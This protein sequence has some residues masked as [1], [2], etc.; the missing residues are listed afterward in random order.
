MSGPYYKHAEETASRLVAGETVIVRLPDAEMT[1]LSESGGAV[2]ALA[3]G[4][5]TGMEIAAALQA[6][7]GLSEPPAIQAFLDELLER[8]LLATAGSAVPSPARAE[9][10]PEAGTYAPPAVRVAEPLETLAG[11]CDSA[12]TGEPTADC[13]TSA[14][15][16][17]DI[18]T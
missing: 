4:T 12:F 13:R 5:S 15:G 8:G 2:W 3:D 6:H 14:L 10:L 9:P 7:Y 18:I 17:F 16:C 11:G 1:V